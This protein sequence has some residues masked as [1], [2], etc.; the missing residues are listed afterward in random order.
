MSTEL[1]V[2]MIYKELIAQWPWGHL[3]NRKAQNIRWDDE[4]QPR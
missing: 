2:E 3:G 4:K 1:C